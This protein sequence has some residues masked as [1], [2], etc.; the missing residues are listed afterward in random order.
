MGRREARQRSRH[1][2]RLRTCREF[3]QDERGAEVEGTLT[4]TPNPSFVKIKM[5]S[6]CFPSHTDR[7]TL[8]KGACSLAGL[9]NRDILPF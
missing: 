9:F 2:E 6:F 8:P 3:K 4:D 7:V 5:T 1:C